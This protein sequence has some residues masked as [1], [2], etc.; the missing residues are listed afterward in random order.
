MFSDYRLLIYAGIKKERNH[1]NLSNLPH[2]IIFSLQ[3]L[4]ESLKEYAQFLQTINSLANTTILKK[5]LP[6]A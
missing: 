2:I 5:W 6:N 3:Q 1:P 4:L